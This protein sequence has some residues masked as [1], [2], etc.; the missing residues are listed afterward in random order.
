MNYSTIAIFL[1]FC[2]FVDPPMISSI[3]LKKDFSKKNMVSTRKKRQSNRRLPSQLENFDQHVITG[4]AMN[5]GQ[6]KTTVNEGTVD[7]EFTAGNSDS[8]PAFNKI[9]VNVKT[10]E[11]CFYGRIVREMGRIVHTVEDST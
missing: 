6:E 9:V 8:C 3:E 1:N 10:L 4:N 5:N 11:T 2:C 7:Q